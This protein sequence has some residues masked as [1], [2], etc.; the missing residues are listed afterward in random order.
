MPFIGI[1]TRFKVTGKEPWHSLVQCTARG[2]RNDAA[3]KDTVALPLQR[4]GNFADFI[5]VGRGRE[6]SPYCGAAYLSWNDAARR[7]LQESTLK[8]R[9]RQEKS[10][11]RFSIAI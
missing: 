11:A 7:A 5:I 6:A 8:H 9:G 10:A 1:D 4:V 3:R 2:F